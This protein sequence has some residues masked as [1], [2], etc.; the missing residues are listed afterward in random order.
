MTKK[1]TGKDI[2][3]KQSTKKPAASESLQDDELQEVSG[4][5]LVTRPTEPIVG[6]PVCV[7]NL[8]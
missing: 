8:S 6:K 5:L 2:G 1:L 7:S 3:T 4:G